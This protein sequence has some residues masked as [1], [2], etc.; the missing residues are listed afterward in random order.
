[1][2]LRRTTRFRSSLVFRITGVALCLAM[3]VSF[4]SLVRPSIRAR[5][6]FRKLE[7][8]PLGHATFEDAQRLAKTIGA[9]PTGT[10]CDRS[11]CEWDVKMDNSEIP[12]WWRG[13]GETFAVYFDVENSVVV[14]KG[15]GYGIG[16]ESDRFNPSQVG[17]E[18]QENWGRIPRKEPITAGWYT[19]NLHRYDKFVVYRTPKASAEERRRY[20]AYNFNCLCNTEDAKMEETCCPLRAPI[21]WRH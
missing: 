8:L 1:M 20:T 18:E 14:R 15:T 17:L 12:R 19:S 5:N 2:E 4:A 10:A 21:P 9:K 16:I 11:F 3:L 6:L 7:T 13:S